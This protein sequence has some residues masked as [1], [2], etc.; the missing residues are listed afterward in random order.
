MNR[1]KWKQ[2]K[3]KIKQRWNRLPDDKL[4]T[5]QGKRDQ[6]VR[7]LHNEYGYVWEQAE[8]KVNRFLAEHNV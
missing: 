2:L 3:G 4:D 6:L 7:L 8:E 5:W 1:S